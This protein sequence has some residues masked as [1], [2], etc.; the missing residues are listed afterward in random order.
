MAK[1]DFSNAPGMNAFF[2]TSAIE[3]PPKVKEEPKKKSQPQV[4]KAKSENKEGQT[5]KVTRSPKSSGQKTEKV[6]S[7]SSEKSKSTFS[8]DL[9]G[10]RKK[11]AEYTGIRLKRELFLRLQTIAEKEKLKSTNSLISTILEAYCDGYEGVG[12]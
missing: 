5:K 2:Q 6:K 7:S 1:K 11:G 3:T 12:E 4:V 10:L 9:N 8:V